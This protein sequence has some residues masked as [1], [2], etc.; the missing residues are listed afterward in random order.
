MSTQPD[1]NV[2]GGC[3]KAV[4]GEGVFTTG[5][6]VDTLAGTGWSLSCS[7]RTP[8][9]STWPQKFTNDYIKK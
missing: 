2:L 5:R 8:G 9:T 1:E 3:T 6:L 4:G 7:D